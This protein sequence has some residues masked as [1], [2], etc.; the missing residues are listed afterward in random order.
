MFTGPLIDAAE[1]ASCGLVERVV[2]VDAVDAAVQEWAAA[3]VGAA[4][5]VIR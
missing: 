5:N 3:I 4:P 2:A 1:S